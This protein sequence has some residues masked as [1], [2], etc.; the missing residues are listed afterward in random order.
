MLKKFFCILLGISTASVISSGICMGESVDSFEKNTGFEP[1]PVYVLDE[2]DHP[3]TLESFYY[4]HLTQNFGH[5]YK[6]SCG[7]V[8]MG[9]LLSYYDTFLNDSI[10]PDQYD[11]NSLGYGLDLAQRDNN[12]GV[13]FENISG[14]KGMSNITYFEHVTSMNNSFHGRLLEIGDEAGFCPIVSMQ[15]NG[16]TVEDMTF[17]TSFNSRKEILNRYFRGDLGY[18]YGVEYS[19]LG[20]NRDSIVGNLAPVTRNTFESDYKGDWINNSNDVKAYAIDLIQQGYPVII[21]GTKAV[22]ETDK[23]GVKRLHFYGHAVVAYDYN[24]ATDSLYCHMGWNRTTTHSTLESE[25]YTFYRSALAI[26]FNISHRDSNNYGWEVNG[27]TIYFSGNQID[28]DYNLVHDHDY[29]HSYKNMSTQ[30][31]AYCA[32]GEHITENHSYGD[33]YS[34]YNKKQHKAYCACGTYVLRP[35]VAK[36]SSTG[37]IRGFRYSVCEECGELIDLTTTPVIAYL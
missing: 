29:C 5:N 21:G 37:G 28:D 7:Y 23:D 4:S 17:G 27:N 22:E 34:R 31:Y 10:I 14:A 13:L 19:L 18:K 8:A 36:A 25:G 11:V 6:G 30:H 2:E 16:N 1:N 26:K 20:L 35:H 12:P 32:C 33:H 15:R 9:M 24:Q 3:S